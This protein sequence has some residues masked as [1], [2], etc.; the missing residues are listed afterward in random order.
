MSKR[1][2]IVCVCEVACCLI[3]G[4]AARIAITIIKNIV[5]NYKKSIDN[6]AKDA[7]IEL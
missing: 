1:A 4:V 6:S 5:R 2:I 7:I 3:G